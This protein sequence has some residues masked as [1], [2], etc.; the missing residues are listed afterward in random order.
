MITSPIVNE[1][2]FAVLIASFGWKIGLLYVLLGILVGVVGGIVVGALHM[3]KQVEE[4]VYQSAAT[5]EIE[6]YQPT[7]KERLIYS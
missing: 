6:I 2:A 5:N 3:E 7:L 1:A 4:Y